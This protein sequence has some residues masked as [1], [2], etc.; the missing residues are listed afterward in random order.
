MYL[1]SFY[2][3][4]FEIVVRVAKIS[5]GSVYKLYFNMF[6]YIFA[7]IFFS[8]LLSLILREYSYYHYLYVGLN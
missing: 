4:S 2:Q 5:S 8:F 6:V 7:C 1:L 3:L